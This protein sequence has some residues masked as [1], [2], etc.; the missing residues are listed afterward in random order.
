MRL[1][2]KLL[3]CIDYGLDVVVA[4]ER[5]KID[6]AIHEEHVAPIALAVQGRERERTDGVARKTAATPRVLRH[7]HWT[8]T[9]RQRQQLSE[10]APIERQIF[11]FL[12]VNDCS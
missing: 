11:H 3:H 10:I 6:N 5:T 7:A 2:L 12:F 4:N 1:N 8:G 9:W